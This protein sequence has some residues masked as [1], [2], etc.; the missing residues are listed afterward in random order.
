MTFTSESVV[1]DVYTVTRRRSAI[2]SS[3]FIYPPAIR[4]IFLA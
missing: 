1:A 4:R 3:L 2:L